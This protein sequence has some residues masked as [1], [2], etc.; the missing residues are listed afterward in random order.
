MFIIVLI[1]CGSNHPDSL[2]PRLL[3]VLAECWE[4]GS[5]GAAPGRDRAV[6]RGWG[7]E[8]SSGHKEAGAGG[9][10]PWPGI[11]SGG[12]GGASHPYA[13]GEKK[14]ATKY[15]SEWSRLRQ[16]GLV[17]KFKC[18]WNC[19]PCVLGTIFKCFCICLCSYRILSSSWTKKRQ[20]DRSSR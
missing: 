14:N 7:D 6:C 9:D 1:L 2:W 13:N 16:K 8:S 15:H 18:R 11:S 19:W 20:P 17:K 5:S 3:S 12:R 10:P 4:A